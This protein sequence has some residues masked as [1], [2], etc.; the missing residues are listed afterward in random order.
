V[1]GWSAFSGERAAPAPGVLS[2]R[3]RRYTTSGRAAIALALRALEIRWG[4]KVLVPTYHCPTMIAP[5][6]RSG[7]QPMFYPITASGAVDLEWLQRAALDGVRAMLATHYFGIPQPMSTLR[8]FCDVHRIALIEDCAHAFFGVSEGVAAGSWGDLAI[9][10]LPKFFPV[11]EG[12]LVLSATRS[13]KKLDLAACKWR[14]EVKAVVD[15]V[16]IG[17]VHG[18]FPGLN[19]PLGGLFRLK[20]WLRR[21]P[22]DALAKRGSESATPAVDLR[23]DSLRPAVAARWISSGVHLSRIVANRRRNYAALASS[24]SRIDGAHALRSDLPEDATP[25]VFPLYV[26][27]PA[28]SYQRLR[29]AGIPLFRWDEIWPGT[30]VLNGD[31]GLDWAHRVFQL[32]CHQDLSLDDIE[33][34]AITVRECIRP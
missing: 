34:M 30:P 24:L 31:H 4:D 14:D 25:Y 16:E 22:T 1:L 23:L 26:N 7:A 33:A 5:V 17:V 15:A 11:P 18:R 27:D 9:A 12:G 28:A 6:V 10:S 20:N 3:Y 2:A 21:R 32:G 29:S 8:A 19:T 13:L